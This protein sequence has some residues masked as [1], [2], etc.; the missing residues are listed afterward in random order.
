MAANAVD[1]Y[2]VG[3]IE[4]GGGPRFASEA[5]YDVFVVEEVLGQEFERGGPR[6]GHVLGSVHDAHTAFAELAHD[7][8]GP[9]NLPDERILASH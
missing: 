5:L 1:G 7:F 6:E 3:V 9:D 8:V 2:D 4:P